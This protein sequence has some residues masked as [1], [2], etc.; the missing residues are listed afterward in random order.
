MLLLFVLSLSW[1]GF[2]LEKSQFYSK[3][4]PRKGS[5]RIS[6]AVFVKYKLWVSRETLI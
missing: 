2:S 5:I 6:N 4:Q 3:F 1:M